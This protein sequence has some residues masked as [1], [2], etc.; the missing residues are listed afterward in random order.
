MT[1]TAARLGECLVAATLALAFAR[2]AAAISLDADSTMRLGLRAYT[3][4]R[5]GTE[6]IGDQNAYAWPKS[7]SS[8]PHQ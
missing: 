2:D 7:E 1:S 5:V 3:A 6:E 8:A 4:V